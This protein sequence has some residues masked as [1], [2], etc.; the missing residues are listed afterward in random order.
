MCDLLEINQCSCRDAGLILLTMNDA[1]I[2]ILG[3]LSTIDI[4]FDPERSPIRSTPRDR[5]R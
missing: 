1:T 3:L 2:E 4:E 5:R